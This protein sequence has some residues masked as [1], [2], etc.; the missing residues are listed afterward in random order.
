[1]S[2]RSK[3][4]RLLLPLVVLALGIGGMRLL[5]HARKPPAPVATAHPGPLVEVVT[6]HAGDHRVTVRAT[7]TVEPARAVA[8]TPEVSGRVVEVAP[9]LVAGG[10]FR[11]G[12][13]LFAIEATD[14]RLAVERARSA[15]AQ[16]L[17]ELTTTEGRA[18]VARQEWRSLHPDGE[19]PPPLVVYKPQL[20]AAQ[21]A[22][23]AAEA[24]VDEAGLNLARTR[25]T[26]PF[27]CRVRSEEVEVGQVVRPGTVVAQV[28]GTDRAEVVVPLSPEAL[29][30]ITVPRADGG[31]SRPGSRATVVVRR[32][33][34][35]DRWPGQVVRSLG[36]VDPTSRMARVVVAVEDPYQL[37]HREPHR[38][39]LEV[40]RFVEV[41][42][43][44]ERL[45][46]VVAIPRRAVG[47]EGRVGVVGANNRL[48]LRA[49]SVVWREGETLF[50]DGGVVDGERV[51]LTRL[52][53]A[54]DGMLLRP[55]E[56]KAAGPEAAETTTPASTTIREPAEAER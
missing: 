42:I 22:V 47:P 20:A 35:E 9:N 1:M 46:G 36:E 30:A 33:D 8:I 32:G 11:E 3:L 44:G 23:A 29:A 37:H 10:L 31:R 19:P 15:L 43:T 39:N 49:V 53:G 18:A 28:A 51:V 24:S 50:T 56:A 45:T 16:A 14:Y 41:E 55:V 34:Q 6:V 2:L 25:V 7:G 13:P 54:A 38:A 40:G 17:V 48:A 26:A 21:A 27:N 5:L 52:T 12:E 4:V